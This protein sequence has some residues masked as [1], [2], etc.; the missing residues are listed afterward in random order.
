MPIWLELF[1]L[2]LFVYAAGLCLGWLIWG[3]DSSGKNI[4]G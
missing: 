4:D 2:L 1:V 3:R